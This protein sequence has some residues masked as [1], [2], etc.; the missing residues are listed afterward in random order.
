MEEGGDMLPRLEILNACLRHARAV[1]PELLVTSA[2][3]ALLHASAAGARPPLP[4][5]LDLHT[6]R[7]SEGGDG[8]EGV[9]FFHDP[10]GDCVAVFGAH[11]SGL[12]DVTGDGV[13]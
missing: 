4:A 1:R 9:V 13:D 2:V 7:A 12:G 6:L 10:C 8:S 5:V 3:I 11:V